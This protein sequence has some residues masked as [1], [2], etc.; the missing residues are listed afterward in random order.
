MQFLVSYIEPTK[1]GAA[2]PDRDPLHE[3]YSPHRQFLLT[4]TLG[5]CEEGCNAKGC[6]SLSEG[7]LRKKT[8]HK[9]E[10]SQT[11]DEGRKSD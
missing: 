9:W 4:I 11:L 5:Q 10:Q 2:G 3:G 7:V 8:K 1:C 6:L